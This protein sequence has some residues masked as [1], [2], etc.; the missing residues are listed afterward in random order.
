MEGVFCKCCDIR[1]FQ[2]VVTVV[3]LKD[4]ILSFGGGLV[5]GEG[6]AD[7]FGLIRCKRGSRGY[8]ILIIGFAVQLS[9]IVLK[10]IHVSVLLLVATVQI[11]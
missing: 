8:L 9:G 11:T 2:V 5:L 10:G 1:K 3:A 6:E 4:L 7:L